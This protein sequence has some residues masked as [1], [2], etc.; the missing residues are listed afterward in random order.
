[1]GVRPHDEDLLGQQATGPGSP[2]DQSEC[3]PAEQHDGWA[4]DED[5]D[6]ETPGEVEPEEVAPDADHCHGEQGRVHDAP[7]LLD[8]RTEHLRLI[9]PEGRDREHPED[10]D[11]R[12]G[13]GNR[14]HEVD[15]GWSEDPETLTAQ[16]GEGQDDRDGDDVDAEREEAQQRDRLGGRFLAHPGGREEGFRRCVARGRRGRPRSR[17]GD[18]PRDVLCPGNRHLLGP[19]PR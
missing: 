3:N 5:Q 13:S 17:H 4:E 8:A 11:H 1:V 15:E 19:H 6:V 14:R 10:R 12:R 7:V 2:Q 18:R 9:T 16:P